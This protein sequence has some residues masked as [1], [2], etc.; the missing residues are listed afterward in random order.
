[1]RH[2]DEE[3]IKMKNVFLAAIAALGLAAAVAP[4]AEAARN[5]ANTSQHSGPYD[6]TGNGPGQTGLEGGGG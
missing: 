5:T 1:V 4:A 3:L 6:N 2:P